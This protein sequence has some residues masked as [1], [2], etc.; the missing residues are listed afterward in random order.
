R[1]MQSGL[2][3]P[4]GRSPELH[5]HEKMLNEK[6][7]DPQHREAL[8]S[9]TALYFIEEHALLRPELLD[10]A[11]KSLQALFL[12]TSG[13]ETMLRKLIEILKTTKLIHQS[14]ASISNVLSGITRGVQTVD[15]KVAAYKQALA[16]ITPNAEENA[17]FAG[18]FL[19]FSQTLLQKLDAFDNN[20]RQYVELKETEA[21]Y[22]SIYHIAMEARERL[23][24]FDYSESESNLQFAQRDARNK[25]EEIL[26]QLEDIRVMCQMAK[27]PAMRDKTDDSANPTVSFLSV[28]PA[29]KTLRLKSDY[30]DVFAMF[31]HALRQHPRLLQLKDIVLEL[32]RLYQNSYGMFRLDC[33]RLGKAMETMFDNSEA[34][35]EAKEEDKDI[36]TKREKLM[37]IEG[38]IPFL[39]HAAVLTT[40]NPAEV[41]GRFSRRL[42]DMISEKRAAWAAITEQLL[43]AKVQAEAELSTRL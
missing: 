11:K 4:P 17:A 43:R 41:Y 42:S 16:T 22:A 9:M 5:R 29:T 25:E 18:P 14:F 39:E 26:A 30:D 28:A 12:R 10:D 1:A 33:D 35:F 24:S 23:K 38:L 21:R 3:P 15:G 8:V 40:D 32:F 2:V 7:T 31:S 27:N 13:E 37:M 6:S 19:S 34:Y 20:M 36:R